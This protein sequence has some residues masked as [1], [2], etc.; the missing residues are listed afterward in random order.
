MVNESKHPT[1]LRLALAAFLGVSLAVAAGAQMAP[2][3]TQQA[4][5]GQEVTAWHV[6][7][8][9]ETM[10]SITA[11][12]LGSSDRWQENHRLNPEVRDPH[13]IVPG[14]RLRVLLGADLPARVALIEQLANRVES[15]LNPLPWQAA[16]AREV[17]RSSDAVRTFENASAE[18]SLERHGS[19]IVTEESIVY[20]RTGSLEV[21]RRQA[22]QIE[23]EVGQ[24]DYAADRA[25]PAKAAAGAAKGDIEIVLGTARAAPKAGADGIVR[26]RARVDA[27][28]QS[29]LMVYGGTSAL[30]TPGGSVALETGTGTSVAADG[31]AAPPE[32]LLMAPVLTAPE[33]SASVQRSGATFSWQAV[34]GAA[35]YLVEICADPRCAGLVQRAT[36]IAST[37]W[38][39]RGLPA[40]ELFWRAT[41]RSASGLD[42][43]PSDGRAVVATDVPPPPPDSQPPFAR[44]RFLGPQVTIPA[45]FLIGRGTSIEVETGDVGGSGV[46]AWRAIVDGDTVAAASLGGPWATGDHSLE[47]EVVDGA[48]NR[49]AHPPVAFAYDPVPPVLRWGRGPSSMIGETQG[50]GETAA[51]R[52]APISQRSLRFEWAPG[53]GR[54]WREFVGLAG[55][56]KESPRIGLRPA[57][58]AFRLI[59]S[60]MIISRASPLWL[61]AEDELCRA[62]HLSVLVLSGSSGS[63]LVVDAVDL[64]G[65]ATRQVWPLAAASAK[66]ARSG[67]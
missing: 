63:R 48:G 53:D 43:Y 51:V 16:V 22:A 55:V 14:Q 46:E 31:K 23:I 67:R 24:A 6:V 45:R 19:L 10:R 42:G 7:R 28:K 56:P 15:L 4:A 57:R 26:T 62:V 5:T 27:A 41:A 65:N 49:F 33:V 13:L 8:A 29:Q 3:Q 9:G 40:G 30:E 58:G 35:S 59:G 11:L 64:L 25:Q 17:L 52:G 39:T 60:D 20:L 66:E 1:L 18:L 44:V 21:E 61:E 12:Y 37:S 47:I 34:T 32:R 2:R 38:Q 54:S 36:D 50:I